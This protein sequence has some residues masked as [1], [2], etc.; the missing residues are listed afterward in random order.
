[1]RTSKSRCLAILFVAASSSP[2]DKRA[3]TIK[4]GKSPARTRPM[5]IG[6][7]FGLLEVSG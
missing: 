3:L 7:S 4:A 6:P 5:G 2:E 1:M